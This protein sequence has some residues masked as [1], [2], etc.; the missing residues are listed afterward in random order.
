MKCWVLPIVLLSLWFF[1][2]SAA[3]GI[4]NVGSH[5]RILYTKA[6]TELIAFDLGREVQMPAFFPAWGSRK[7]VLCVFDNCLV[8]FGASYEGCRDSGDGSWHY[9]FIN[10]LVRPISM[11]DVPNDFDPSTTG[12]LTQIIACT[13]KVLAR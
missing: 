13:G 11:D 12:K 8:K 9:L 2:C 6:K 1:K 3:Q 4:W 5:V 7:L 10:W